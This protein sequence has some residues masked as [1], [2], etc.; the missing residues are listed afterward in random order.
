[1]RNVYIIL[2]KKIQRKASNEKVNKTKSTKKEILCCL[3]ISLCHQYNK[4]KCWV[5]HYNYVKYHIKYYKSII[6]MIVLRQKKLQN[7][8][9]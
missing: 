1:M 5:L 6:K 8:N 2:R 9:L 3:Y 4:Y 7:L